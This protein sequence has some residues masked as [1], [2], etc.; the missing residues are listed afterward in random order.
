MRSRCGWYQS[1]TASDVGRPAR[2]AAPQRVEQ[3]RDQR[4]PVSTAAAGGRTNAA[5]RRSGSRRLTTHRAAWPR[6]PGRC[7]AAAAAT[8]KPATRSRGFSA[9]RRIAS[10]SLTCAASRNLR[11]PNLTNGM[12]RRA[13]S[14]SSCAL[15][16][17]AAEQHRLRLQRDPGFAVLEDRL[18]DVARPG[19]LRR[20]RSPVAASPP[21]SARTRGS[22]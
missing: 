11:P 22:W 8:R 21:T 18:D 17:R 9:Q 19:R 14:I 20:G 16:L 1:R 4:R 2:P 3:Q 7:P 12:L 10:R 6:S 5:T 13:S 15:W